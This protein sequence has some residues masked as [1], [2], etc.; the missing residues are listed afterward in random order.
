MPTRATRSSKRKRELDEEES[1]VADD[2]VQHDEDDDEEDD[3][4][5]R[6]RKNRKRARRSGRGP[7]KVKPESP[8]QQPAADHARGPSS[9]D[10]GKARSDGWGSS[11]TVT[12]EDAAPLDLASTSTLGPTTTT[13]SSSSTSAPD[14]VNVDELTR[15]KTELAQKEALLKSHQAFAKQILQLTVRFRLVLLFGLD[16]SSFVHSACR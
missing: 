15:L 1:A 7:N 12:A 13:N 3:E 9:A 2:V 10:K 6:T 11:P 14:T 4:E 5:Y 8:Q 16:H